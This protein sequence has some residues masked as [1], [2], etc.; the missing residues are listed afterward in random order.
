MGPTEQQGGNKERKKFSPNRSLKKKEKRKKRNSF[1]MGRKQWKKVRIEQ[2][3]EGIVY[4]IKKKSY[5][6]AER[7]ISIC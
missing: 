6:A 5:G 2:K 3:V 1:I 7:V 4:R